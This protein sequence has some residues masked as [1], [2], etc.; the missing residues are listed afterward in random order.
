[1]LDFSGINCG[2]EQIQIA[3]MGLQYNRSNNFL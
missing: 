3:F 1:M 2:K